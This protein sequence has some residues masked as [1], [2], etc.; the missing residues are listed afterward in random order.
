MSV[1]RGVA[2]IPPPRPL[3]ARVES[4]GLTSRFVLAEIQRQKQGQ[5]MEPDRDIVPR[6]GLERFVAQVPQHPSEKGLQAVAY[7]DRG[8]LGSTGPSENPKIPF[9]KRNKY[10]RLQQKQYERSEN[11]VDRKHVFSVGVQTFFQFVVAF[12]DE[13]IG[14]REGQGHEGDVIKIFDEGSGKGGEARKGREHDWI[15]VW[16]CG[17]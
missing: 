1:Q 13:Q 9:L 2:P 12:E 15:N 11:A 5:M 4:S 17:Q 16:S 3:V 14:Q 10:I 7:H 6:S 8:L